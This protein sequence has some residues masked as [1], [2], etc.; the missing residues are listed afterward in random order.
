MRHIAGR[1]AL[2]PLGAA[3]RFMAITAAHHRSNFIHPFVD[4]NGRVS[5]LTSHAM[6]HKAGIG[7]G[8][9]QHCGAW[10]RG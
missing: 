8:F 3:A 9:G 1:F 4:G 6:S 5:C 10:R 2:A 7:H